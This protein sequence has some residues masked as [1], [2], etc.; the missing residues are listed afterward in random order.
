[1]HA[2]WNFAVEALEHAAVLDAM[3]GARDTVRL[4][5]VTDRAART[6][7]GTHISSWHATLVDVY[8]QDQYMMTLPVADAWVPSAL[9]LEAEHIVGVYAAISFRREKHMY[10]SLDVDVFLLPRAFN[11]AYPLSTTDRMLALFTRAEPSPMDTNSASLVYASLCARERNSD[12]QMPEA[13]QPRFLHPT[14]LPFQR[15]SVAFLLERE[16]DPSARKVLQSECGPWWIKVETEPPCYFHVLSGMLTDSVALAMQDVRA[17]ML[18]E[19]MGLGKT[20]EILA[21]LL[22]RAEPARSLCAPYWDTENEIEVQPVGTTMIVAPETL[23]RQWI[24]E[25]ARHAPSL[26][27]YSF[28]GHKQVERDLKTS[29]HAAW[30]D[31]AKEIDVLVLSFDTLAREL[32]VSK[33]GSVRQLRTPAK[34]ERPRSPLVQI[35]FLRV[36]M[37]EVQLVG[38]NAAQTIALIRRR[39]SIAVSGTPVRRLDDLRACL[40]FM[41]VVHPALPRRDWQRVLSP[42]LAPHLARVLGMVG[43]RH[44]KA[45]I[46]HEMVLP[47]QTRSLVPVDFTYTEAAFYRDVWIESLEALGMDEE[48]AP[49][50][51][52]W[53]LDTAVLRAQL[54]R[55]RQACTHPQVALRG[56]TLGAESGGGHSLVNLRSID[57]VLVMMLESTRAELMTMRHNL[58]LKRIYRAAVLLFAPKEEWDS[59]EKPCK[60]ALLSHQRST[61][62]V[63]LQRILSEGRLAVAHEQLEMLLPE[64]KAQ[65]I[66]L[67]R[68]LEEAHSKGPLYHFTQ[69]E[70]LR[71]ATY[72]AKAAGH[73]W[74][75][76]PDAPREKLKARLQ[77]V[78][79]I[80]NRLRHWLQIQ[81]RAQQFS[82][83]CYFQRGEAI[84]ESKHA[85]TDAHSS[86][87]ALEDAAYAAAEATRHVLLTDARDAV[88][89]SVRVLQQQPGV[90]LAELSPSV[91]VP[92]VLHRSM[93]DMA[94]ERL[95]MLRQHAKLTLEWRAQML[96]R[97]SKPVNREV[98][99]E[100]ENDDVYAENLDAQTEA[101]TLMEM[102]RPLL[103]QREELLTGRIALG[104]T[105]RPQL[106][107][108]L[109]RN[110]RSIKHR[111]LQLNVEEEQE[112]EDEIKQVQKAQLH[113]FLRLEAEQKRVA[114]QPGALSLADILANMREVRD[115]STRAEEVA[116]L[117]SAYTTMQRTLREQTQALERLRKEQAHFQ[118]LFNARSLYFKQIQELSDQVQD[119]V[120][121][122]GAVKSIHAAMEQELAMCQ[123]IG[124]FEGRLRYL[125]HLERIQTG[126]DET[127]Q[128]F[129]C[130]NPMET[131]ILTN[132]C[133]HICC[134]VCFHAWMAKGRRVCPYCKTAISMRDIHRIVYRQESGASEDAVLARGPVGVDARRYR[135]MDPALRARIEQKQTKG[136]YGS[137][138]DLLSQHL[139]YLHDT[140]GEKS[141][142]FSSFSRGLDL[143]AESLCA[144]GIPSLRLQGGG[145]KRAGEIVDMFQRSDVNVLLLHSEMQSAG[146]NLLAASNL[147]LLEPLMNHALE[148][149]AI[150]RVHRIGQTR[151]TNVFCYMVKDT[152][153]QHIV[154][155][156][157]SRGQSLYAEGDTSAGFMDSAALL[158]HNLQHAEKLSLE[159][160]RG[161]LMGSTDELLACLFQQHSKAGNKVQENTDYL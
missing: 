12:T 139:V 44:T 42:P 63:F 128:C 133:G 124:A 97:L 149:Q 121:E 120:M 38:G 142:I 9:A 135:A 159:A 81:H 94:A 65:I 23:R 116:L 100:R 11:R 73:D 61:E 123:R 2:C 147:F 95:A 103:A 126:N 138:L 140:T 31:W 6:V 22:E 112:E 20:V 85:D 88:E 7:P 153:E 96:E 35:E 141:L 68:E 87:R 80:R 132:A 78:V 10:A 60:E 79:T 45:D 25:I 36:V 64:V 117:S 84:G 1:M 55:L 39:A 46:A 56:H 70:L 21:L 106:F 86:L 77:H 48:G 115:A 110:H 75:H 107:A 161:D 33:K 151:A 18:S 54:L 158:A 137:K 4:S 49:Q 155:S 16:A 131:G 72:E 5:L 119:P 113:H 101:E 43:I 118:V 143:V 76:A 15:R 53:Q 19:E 69:E 154:A 30:T 52:D 127:R 90:S 125:Q 41:A 71:E 105:A 34:Y 99:K 136:Q 104:S 58:A 51:D 8:A 67:E 91:P 157:A 146:L 62:A 26:R 59:D 29:G 37:D 14:L 130:T 13:L 83:H 160:R 3:D 98:D 32:N 50:L 109:D 82:G 129:I 66:E 89:Q 134:E 93:L 156:T 27:V 40:C 152:V 144:N 47:P 102:Y 122:D 150:G 114:L 108:E 148:L 28:T 17:A 92:S 57:Q 24:D 145:S 74:M 111:R